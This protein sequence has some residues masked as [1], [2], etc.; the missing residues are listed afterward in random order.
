MFASDAAHTMS[1]KAVEA[2]TYQ[3]LPPDGRRIH[4]EPGATQATGGETGGRCQSTRYC[5]LVPRSI[6]ELPVLVIDALLF[7]QYFSF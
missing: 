7:Y 2:G 6:F 4:Q 1:S 3:G 5:V